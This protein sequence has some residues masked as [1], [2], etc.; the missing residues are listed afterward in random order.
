M[1]RAKYLSYRGNLNPHRNDVFLFRNLYFYFVI[2]KKK[3]INLIYH[4]MGLSQP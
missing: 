3:F 2:G 4:E 1:K